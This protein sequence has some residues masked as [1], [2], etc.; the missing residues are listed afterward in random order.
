MGLGFAAMGR[1]N[2]MKEEMQMTSR[3]SAG[4]KANGQDPLGSNAEIGRKLKQYYEE[5]VSED[6]PD[7][8][9][10]LLRQLES[11]EKNPGSRHKDRS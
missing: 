8:F 3:R 5:L 9:V 7:R 4:S 10:D 11:S 2:G 6:V 1:E